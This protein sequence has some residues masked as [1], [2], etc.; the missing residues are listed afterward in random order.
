MR[1]GEQ[2]DRRAGRRTLPIYGADDAV[3]TLATEF[4]AAVIP[5]HLAITIGDAHANA[6]KA[7]VVVAQTLAASLATSVVATLQAVAGVERA[8]P[9]VTGLAAQTIAT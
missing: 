2:S 9:F 5:A 3:R 7:Q 6:L 8:E 4:P 1:T